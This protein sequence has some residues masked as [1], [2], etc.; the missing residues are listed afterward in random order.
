M[1]KYLINVICTCSTWSGRKNASYYSKTFIV[2][3]F[4]VQKENRHCS[5]AVI[6][7]HSFILILELHLLLHFGQIHIIIQG[8]IYQMSGKSL[9]AQGGMK[10][11]QITYICCLKWF[12]NENDPIIYFWQF[13]KWSTSPFVFTSNES[14]WLDHHSTLIYKPWIETQK[15][16][17]NIWRNWDTNIKKCTFLS[18]KIFSMVKPSAVHSYHCLRQQ[19]VPRVR[20]YLLSLTGPGFFSCSSTFGTQS[21]CKLI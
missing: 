3:R 10:G 16:T 12:K 9:R 20:E 4:E 11:G 15:H 6:Y 17:T 21:I 19:R 13:N 1:K 14:R 5:V 8:E 7:F 2:W 18:A